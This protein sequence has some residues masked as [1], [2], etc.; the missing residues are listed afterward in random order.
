MPYRKSCPAST[1]RWGLSSILLLLGAMIHFHTTH[2]T[3][4]IGARVWNRI[5]QPICAI[6]CASDSV[7][8]MNAQGYVHGDLKPEN[9]LWLD[10]GTASSHV[11]LFDFDCSFQ[12]INGDYSNIP[13]RGTDQYTAPE[14]RNKRMRSPFEMA[15]IYLPT[16]DVYSLGV[17]TTLPSFSDIRGR[18]QCNRTSYLSSA[19]AKIRA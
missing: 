16:L 11:A 7:A 3:K 10:R 4:L 12:Y 15:G 2:C 9:L 1:K 5:P 8:R 19:V 13:T 18:K 14:L 6:F 17:S